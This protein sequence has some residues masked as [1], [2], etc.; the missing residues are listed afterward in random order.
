MVLAS[1]ALL[2]DVTAAGSGATPAGYAL[3]ADGGGGT[4]W[5]EVVGTGG[6]TADSVAWDDVTGKPATFPATTHTHTASQV[7]DATTLGRSLMTAASAAAAR[8]AIGAAATGPISYDALP[9]GSVLTVMESAGTY[10][11]PTARA[12]LCVIFTGASD[13]GSVAVDGDKWDQTA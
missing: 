3:T 7:S 8:S 11:R 13:P 5:A 10:T 4:Q 1:A 9:A 2:S 12:D 6:G